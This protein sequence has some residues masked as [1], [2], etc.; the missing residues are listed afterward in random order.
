M[1][2]VGCDR[3]RAT[4]RWGL[5]L[6]KENV[7]KNVSTLFFSFLLLKYTLHV[8]SSSS[9]APRRMNKRL[10]TSV[11]TPP[12]H[13]SFAH[14]LQ[15]EEVPCWVRLCV[16]GVVVE[17]YFMIRRLQQIQVFEGLGGEETFHSI[18][19]LPV[20]IAHVGVVTETVRRLT[21][22]LDRRENL[23]SPLAV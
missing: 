23:P 17:L 10:D 4:T 19:R 22:T 15:L 11:F 1:R 16:E 3:R 5:Y 12:S 8:A 14:L 18:L 21:P 6:E 20:N 9:P 2:R 13:P 7:S